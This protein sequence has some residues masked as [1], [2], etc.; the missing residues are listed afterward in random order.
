MTLQP[1]LNLNNNSFKQ[2]QFQKH[3][4]VY[5]DGKLSFREYLQIMVK[6]VYKKI[7]LL[8]KLR[9]NL[10]RAL[11]VRIYKSFKKLHLDYGDILSDLMFNNCFHE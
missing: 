11:L 4:G 6:K 5:L 8:F 7:S 1:P 3:F 2:V 10:P 9:N